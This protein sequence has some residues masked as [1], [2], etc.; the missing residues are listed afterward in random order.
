MASKQL[1]FKLQKLCQ[2]QYVSNVCQ[3]NYLYDEM[4]LTISR[5]TFSTF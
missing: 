1:T 5:M 4:V 2:K 3:H